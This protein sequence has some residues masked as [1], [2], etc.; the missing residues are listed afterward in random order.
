MLLFVACSSS[1]S[2]ENK[3]L[4]ELY[5]LL[6]SEIARSK[7]YEDAKESKIKQLHDD[8]H[9]ASDDKHRIR[10]VN[11]LISEFDAYNA[12]ST[13]YY[14]G[15]NLQLLPPDMS[16]EKTRLLIKRAD[17]YAHAGLFADALLAMAAIKKDSLHGN[18]SEDYYTTYCA[19]YQ[20]LSEYTS[21][22]E[23][24]AGYEH[25]RAAYADSLSRVENLGLFNHRVYIMTEK[26]RNGQA[27]EAIEAMLQQLKNYESGSRQYSILASTLAYIYKTS[28]R[29]DLYKKYLTLSAISDVR[30]AVK[31]NMSF[32]ELATVM[33][34]GGDIERAN[35]Y[36][37]KSI[38]DANFYS[39]LLRNAQ[40][41]KILPVIDDAYT[42]LQ[43]RLTD[44]LRIMVWTGS[45]LSAIL[46]IAICYIL[47][48][49]KSLRTANRRVRQANNELSRMS[50]QL[51]DANAELHIKN[52]E[53][54]SLSGA[55]TNSNNV[56][57]ARNNELNELSNQLKS[58]NIELESKNK[59]LSN[60]NQTKEQ[61]AGLFMEYCSSAISTLQHYQKSLRVLTAQGGNR[62][63]LMKKLESSE[64][65]DKLLKNFYMK[66]DE[67][68]LNIYPSFVDKFNRLLKP[69]ETVV[70]KAG[71]LLNTELRL[72]ALIR[73]GIE[74]STK[75]AEFLR[76]SISTIYTYR[77]KMRKRAI[78]PDT[79]ETD[80]KKIS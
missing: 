61:Y 9:H 18:L 5:T 39:A 76:C 50:R 3:E 6:D 77:S 35:K 65:A 66:F 41:S 32:R 72:F 23:S 22:H 68:I 15:Y 10:I 53:L 26:T 48:Q 7:V 40:S 13:L 78:K 8:Y 45:I 11:E 1:V 63:A 51:K 4:Q 30:G 37:K 17:V 33:F 38:A 12:D 49:F 75:I 20:Y 43:D 57:E 28:G 14:I 58:A 44:R 27:D 71:E 54:S 67:A 31:E 60:Y 73:L 62:A 59:E 74:D 64:T 52:D 25:L 42:S 34:E 56:L 69:D 21:E 70:L 29:K 47:K 80:V 55:L 24:A 79:F 19:I 46:I 16:E 36:L 2:D